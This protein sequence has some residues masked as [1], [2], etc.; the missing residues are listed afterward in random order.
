MAPFKS[1]YFLVAL[2]ALTLALGLGTALLQWILPP[3][4]AVL[5]LSAPAPDGGY[6]WVVPLPKLFLPFWQRAIYTVPPGDGIGHNV[7]L[8]E[9]GKALARPNCFHQ[10]IRDYGN[11]RYSHWGDGLWFSTS[12]NDDPT[13]NGREYMVEIQTTPRMRIL[14]VF[15]L[16][17]LGSA[18]LASSVFPRFAAVLHLARRRL[19]SH[20]VIIILFAMFSILVY[21]GITGGNASNIEL[22]SD[23]GSVCS[24]AAALDQPESFSRDPVFS[25]PEYFAFYH[26][27]HVYWLRFARPWFDSYVHAYAWLA[28]PGVFLHLVGYYLLGLAMKWS[29][30]WSAAFSVIILTTFWVL[31]FATYWGFWHD[32]QPRFLFAAVA[33]FLFAA[34][35]HWRDRPRLW[36]PVMIGAGLITNFHL[37]SGPTAAMMLWTGFL[38]S[39]S[40]F[41]R[42]GHC[43]YL[44]GL[45]LLFLAVSIPGI[46][47]YGGSSGYTNHP[48]PVLR[49][50]ILAS[51]EMFSNVPLGAA[52][53]FRDT[54]G[55]T[56]LVFFAAIGVLVIW[57]LGGDSVKRQLRLW[58]AWGAGIFFA[59]FLVPLL[60]MASAELLDR[61]PLTIDL[62]RGLRF[63]VFLGLLSVVWGAH[64][65]AVFLQGR[66]GRTWP[67][68]LAAPLSLALAAAFCFSHQAFQTEKSWS[69]ALAGGRVVLSGPAAPSP[70]AE[71]HEALKRLPAG[72]LILPLGLDGLSIRHTALRPV[73]ITPKDFNLYIASKGGEL[74]NFLKLAVKA[75]GIDPAYKRF[76]EFA[77]PLG[78][79]DS[80]APVSAEDH[81]RV[82]REI[83]ALTGADVYALGKTTLPPL[84]V[85]GLGGLIWENSLFALV[86]RN[87][88][89]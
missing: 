42:R 29:R 87:K 7:T 54:L 5:P 45:G 66:Y 25:H 71:F 11:G 13:N 2:L 83:G 53:F 43:A 36:V 61:G 19:D 35:M 14:A 65:A 58:L 21:F 24:M 34:A 82:V 85:T 20:A 81:L 46:L 40:G 73:A 67:T 16:S 78:W 30:V 64:E 88:N 44:L 56:G 55:R 51:F 79:P 37:V 89:D 17:A 8:L 77:A 3:P 62:L 22:G 49:R 18:A 63:L 74:R 12:N 68:R 52:V 60:D 59:A 72:T 32:P 57:K 1:K 48:D 10:D 4:R 86:A 41:T 31:P 80:P 6:G 33:G 9:D 23:A 39:A 84:P 15:I 38:F 69:L 76:L 47:V 26:A 70:V 75:A 27:F 50:L 28:I